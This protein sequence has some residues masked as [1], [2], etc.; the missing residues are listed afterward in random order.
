MSEIWFVIF[1]AL[2]FFE[3]ITVNLVSIWF[4]IGSF[5]ALITSFYTE[6][7]TI[8]VIVFVVVSI[9]ALALTN[10]VTNRLRKRKIVP[11]NLDR[12]VGQIG[13]VTK[14]ITK[15]EYGEVKVKGS[16]WTASANKPIKKAS[17]IK[18]ER[19]DG[20]KLIVKEQKED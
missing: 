19:I 8:Q 20:V 17:Y 6:N 2:L 13:I 18:V 3:L 10:K 14:D 4:A 7:I 11:T 15:D 9:I 1:L 12:V 16:I 5:A